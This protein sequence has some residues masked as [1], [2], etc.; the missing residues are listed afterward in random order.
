[1]TRV[2]SQRHKKKK[3][4]LLFTVA[5]SVSVLI[6]KAETYT[7]KDKSHSFLSFMFLRVLFLNFILGS[8]AAAA[9]A[10]TG[11]TTTTTALLITTIII[12]T[13]TTTL[14][15]VVAGCG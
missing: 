2:G 9:A 11:T 1:M 5:G 8:T 14:E 13:T 7:K 15:T 6:V 3:F 4:V 12:I 10:A